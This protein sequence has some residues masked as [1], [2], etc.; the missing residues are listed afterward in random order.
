MPLYTS[1]THATAFH[2]LRSGISLPVSRAEV[3]VFTSIPLPVFKSHWISSQPA[4]AFDIEIVVIYNDVN[5]IVINDDG[6]IVVMRTI[7]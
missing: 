1:P 4:T 3:S 5:I 6:D 2:T 7:C